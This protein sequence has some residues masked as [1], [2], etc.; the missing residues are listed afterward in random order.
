M[1]WIA[2]ST[3][4]KF[5]RNEVRAQWA[6]LSEAQLDAIGGNRTRLIEEL[7]ASYGLTPEQAE[8]QLAYFERSNE[9]LRAVSSR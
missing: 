9:Y 6:K 7:R 1:D 4:W 3:E 2:A 5:F 8:R